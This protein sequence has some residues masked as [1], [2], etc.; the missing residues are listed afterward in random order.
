MGLT[1]GIE[2]G[3]GVFI[4]IEA[5]GF[6]EVAVVRSCSRVMFTTSRFVFPPPFS[7]SKARVLLEF[8]I[9]ASLLLWSRKWLA[10][11]K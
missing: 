6:T 10:V 8:S 4:G 1:C 5:A 2:F 3:A 7:A 11:F 9:R